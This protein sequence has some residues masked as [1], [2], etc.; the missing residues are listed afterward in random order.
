M[1]EGIDFYS[2][3]FIVETHSET[4]FFRLKWPQDR[5]YGF[6]RNPV[7]VFH[8]DAIRLVNLARKDGFHVPDV[9]RLLFLK[10]WFVKA[11][12]G[13]CDDWPALPVL[14]RV[15]NELE[16]VDGRHRCEA[17]L[18]LGATRIPVIVGCGESAGA[19]A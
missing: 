19:K 10:N 14:S 2:T 16:F 4:E 12:G 5:Y 8:I 11:A 6:V 13:S 1:V 3:E 7:Q 17:L 15:G 18:I 9:D